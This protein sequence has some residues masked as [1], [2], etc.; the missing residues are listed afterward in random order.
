MERQL[1][2]FLNGYASHARL[3]RTTEKECQGFDHIPSVFTRF[4]TKDLPT[5]DDAG[6]EAAEEKEEVKTAEQADEH[7]GKRDP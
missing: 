2:E 7:E 6:D 3:P 1:Q 5:S 4:L